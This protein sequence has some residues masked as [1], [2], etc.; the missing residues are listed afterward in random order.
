MS[1]PHEATRDHVFKALDWIDQHPKQV[2]RIRKYALRRGTKGKNYPPKDV[3][4]V[5][6]RFQSSKKFEG[7]FSGGCQANNFL[8]K[9]KFEIWDTSKNPEQRVT[10]Q[11]VEE[12]PEEIFKEGKVLYKYRKHKTIERRPGMA[13]LAK[14]KRMLIDKLLRCEACGFSFVKTYGDLG[15]GFIEAHHKVPLSRLKGQRVA[16][17]SD[18]ALVCANCHRM[19]HQSNPLLPIEKLAKILKGK[20]Q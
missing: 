4:R 8:I 10:I 13:R 2:Q 6:G 5:A 16:R 1:L 17:I 12:D 20:Q 7:I 14:N 11:A 19:I 9:R 3:I 15:L 18:L